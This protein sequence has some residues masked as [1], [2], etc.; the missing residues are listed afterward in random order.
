MFVSHGR[1]GSDHSW[2]RD[3]R[4][5]H[6]RHR[7]QCVL[8]RQAS[9]QERLTKLPQKFQRRYLPSKDKQERAE[10]GYY[11]LDEDD[12][13]AEGSGIDYAINWKAL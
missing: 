1:H 5:R 3:S 10:V 2:C 7:L 4:S 6:N 12:A 13:P 9:P 11:V 8:A